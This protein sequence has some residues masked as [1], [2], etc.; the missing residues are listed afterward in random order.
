MGRRQRHL[1]VPKATPRPSIHSTFH[2]RYAA[3]HGQEPPRPR[4]LP[5]KHYVPRTLRCPFCSPFTAIRAPGRAT[6]TRLRSLSLHSRRYM[7]K[8][9]RV[10][11]SFFIQASRIVEPWLSALLYYCSSETL[12]SIN[13]RRPKWRHSIIHDRVSSST[14]PGMPLH[15]CLHAGLASRLVHH[16]LL[17]GLLMDI[18]VSDGKRHG[19]R[20]LPPPLESPQHRVQAAMELPRLPHTGTPVPPVASHLSG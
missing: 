18:K 19:K 13:G 14:L 6:A 12:M 10:S 2:N 4:Y 7:V 9:R 16:L 1:L 3:V 17:L 11:G 20:Y 8:S 5:L 15:A